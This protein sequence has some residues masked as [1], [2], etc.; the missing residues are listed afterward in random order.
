MKE[1]R[2]ILVPLRSIEAKRKFERFI[3]EKTGRE[4]IYPPHYLNKL[5]MQLVSVDLKEFSET[6]ITC[7]R[8]ATYITDGVDDFIKRYEPIKEEENK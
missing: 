8:C 1:K 2:W 5:V 6:N 7:G 4:F 3:K